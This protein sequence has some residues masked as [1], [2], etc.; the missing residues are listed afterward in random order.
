MKFIQFFIIVVLLLKDSSFEIHCEKVKC[1]YVQRENVEDIDENIEVSESKEEDGEKSY[2]KDGK[3]YEEV[4]ESYEI[5]EDKKGQDD[6]KIRK[7]SN[8]ILGKKS[9]KNFD[10][11]R[12]KS[13]VIKI[14]PSQLISIKILQEN[15]SKKS[16]FEFNL[17]KNFKEKKQHE[18][19]QKS[20]QIK[21][22]NRQNYE[23]NYQQTQ[24]EKAM[25]KNEEYFE[26]IDENLQE[27][28]GICNNCKNKQKKQQFHKNKNKFKENSKET[29]SKIS[30][31]SKNNSTSKFC[32]TFISPSS[33]NNQDLE[34]M[35]DCNEIDFSSNNLQIL[36]IIF[37]TKFS[38]LETVNFDN[39][40]L[41]ILPQNLLNNLINLKNF[42]A[43]NN[44]IE[45]INENFFTSNFHLEFV[46][47][48]FN[49]LRH[50]PM[51]LFIHNQNLKFISFKSNVCVNHE[52]PEITME[53]L[54]GL[55]GVNCN[56]DRNIFAF[57]VKLIQLSSKLSAIGGDLVNE[58]NSSGENDDNKIVEPSDLDVL[59]TGLFWL[60]I[61]II[62]IL[63]GICGM[64][65]YVIYNKFVV[66]AVNARR[67]EGISG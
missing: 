15:E 29:F 22:K 65:F 17:E 12:Q 37:T 63:F 8:E 53:H 23:G 27:S 50:I 51:R 28:L 36:S 61:P 59:F 57:I 42:S 48:S 38:L 19:D 39:N 35:T 5:F 2:D 44:Q 66:Y 10:G 14:N 1:R 4:I 45:S 13:L 62:L 20:Y 47:F 52:Y 64:I 43:K 33:L 26:E 32:E 9:V 16:N 55:V 7:A 41:K 3:S 60:I 54:I 11:N 6:Q 30:Q 67:G 31:P 24:K 40:N 56:D 25:K 58:T 46:N 34:K 21:V 18:N 49:H